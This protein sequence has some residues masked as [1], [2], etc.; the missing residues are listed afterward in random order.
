MCPINLTVYP[1]CACKHPGLQGGNCDQ[2]A[3]FL[4]HG[5]D[6]NTVQRAT[7]VLPLNFAPAAGGDTSAFLG[8][9]ECCRQD[10]LKRGSIQEVNPHRDSEPYTGAL[11]Q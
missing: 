6:P 10:S 7:P 11:F 2:L 5:D 9:S 4:R 3:N 1:G 8:T